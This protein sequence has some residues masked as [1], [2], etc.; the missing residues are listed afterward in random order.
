MWENLG[1]MDGDSFAKSMNKAYPL[2]IRSKIRITRQCAVVIAQLRRHKALV[3][4]SS[5]FV[6][7]QGEAGALSTRLQ[8]YPLP[9]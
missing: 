3:A 2:F 6:T 4:I 8:N 5:L 9:T 1:E 7:I